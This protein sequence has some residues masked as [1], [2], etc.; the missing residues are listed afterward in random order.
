MKTFLYLVLAIVLAVSFFS[1]PALALQE[2]G[3]DVV[4]LNQDPY[5]A[6]PGDYV[7]LV[8]QLNGIDGSNCDRIVF[9]LLPQ[10]P[11]SLDPS[12]GANIT[13]RG[14]IASPDFQTHVL[15]P[16]DIRVDE[17]AVDGNNT[18]EVRY[19]G[20]TNNGLF[21]VEEFEIEIEDLRV[22]FE[23][24]IRDY[25]AATSTLTFDILNI[26][27]HD[28]EAVTL[29]I[30]RQDSVAVKGPNRNIIG[31]LDANEDTSFS[32]EATPS[33]GNI[34]LFVHY[35]DE[36]NVRRSVEKMVAFEPDYFEG[37]NEGS[38]GVSGYI[39]VIGV[40]IIIGIIW[41]IRRKFSRKKEHYHKHSS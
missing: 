29:E 25:D 7:E 26:G 2:C 6:V 10:Y 11:F 3:L 23:I 37:R 19:T 40:I 36:I 21:F 30:P 13:V 20:N 12:A 1:A 39:Y 34:T 27:E 8:F 9:E 33:A 22:D 31:S 14:G 15:I 38:Q 35:T 41:F 24:S 17:Q 5:P 32:F 28:V 4:L 18:I 16:Y